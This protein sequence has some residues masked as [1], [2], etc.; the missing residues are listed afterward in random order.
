MQIK[1][2]D[3]A[4]EDLK[5]IRHYLA[6]NVSPEYAKKITQEIRDEVH[7]LKAMP[8]KGT[9]VVELQNLNMTNHRQLLAD[10]NRIIFERTADIFYIQVVC[11]T[12]MNLQSLLMR[13]LLK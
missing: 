7:S 12:S 3:D 6:R 1:W 5:Q 13:R 11:H 10:Q 9:L 4:K 8:S 2:T